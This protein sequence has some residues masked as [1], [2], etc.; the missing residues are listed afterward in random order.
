MAAADAIGVHEALDRARGLHQE[1]HDGALAEAVRCLELARAH[2]NAVLHCRALALMAAV[3]L[4]RGDLRG[5]LALSAAAELHAER[6]GDDGARAELAAVKAHLSFFAG[7]HA[8]ALV[9]AQ[10]GIDIAD[11]GSDL[12]LRLFVRRS[13]CAVFADVVFSSTRSDIRLRAQRMTHD[14][15]AHPLQDRPASSAPRRRRSPTAVERRATNPRRI[16]LDDRSGREP[17]RLGPPP[18]LP[19]ARATDTAAGGPATEARRT[20]HLLF[21]AELADGTLTPADLEH[22]LVRAAV[23]TRRVPSAARRLQQRLAIKRGSLTARDAL[24][25]GVRVRRAVLGEAAD[26]VPRFLVRM[27]EY[28]HVASLDDPARYGDEAFGTWRDIMAEAGCP[29]LV[30]VLPVTSHAYLDPDGSGGRELGDRE[31]ARLRQLARDGVAFGVHGYD[32]RTRSA[33]P[34]R[35]SELSGLS[36]NQLSDRLDQAEALLADRAGLSPRVFVPPFN[37]FDAQQYGTLAERYDVIC[38]GPESVPLLGFHAS[39]QWR[40][41]A[42]FL[43]AYQPLYG[44]AAEMLPLVRQLI[45]DPSGMWIPVVLHWGWEAE[46]GWDDLRRLADVIAPYAADWSVF[47]DAVDASRGTAADR[48]GEIGIAT[49]AGDSRAA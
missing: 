29:H 49:V 10:R 22:P 6:G 20:A 45:D 7:A 41:N 37:R 26:R 38:G 35:H 48:P 28:P 15:L 46:R 23:A 16:G 14:V 9:Q 18:E 31:V 33:N 39:P 44:T 36:R 13:A 3:M 32:H 30:A 34:R 21:S 1:D 2:E 43:P 11:R 47:L 27:D 19:V 40:G 8:E 42:V 12:E 4:R 25:P 24:A 17:A 5:A